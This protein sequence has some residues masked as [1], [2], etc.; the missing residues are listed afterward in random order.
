[1]FIDV[2]DTREK[3]KIAININLVEKIED[4]TYVGLCALGFVLDNLSDHS[5]YMR[6]S[7]FG[8]NVLFH[9]VA[10]DNQP[11]FVVALYCC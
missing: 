11:Y 7:L 9:P 6:S 2:V 8:G 1:M 4:C 10:E 5:P 3:T